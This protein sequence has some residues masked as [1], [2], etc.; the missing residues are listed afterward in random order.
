MPLPLIA[1]LATGL[2]GLGTSLYGVNK[3]S[4]AVD[5]AAKLNDA[6]QAEQNAAAWANYLMTRGLS[7][8]GATTGQIP[9]GAAAINARLPLWA[10][11]NFARP[12][13]KRVWRKKGAV[14]PVNTLSRTSA[15][16]NSYVSAIASPSM[17]Y[18]D[19]GGG[20]FIPQ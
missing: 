13:A 18:G 12:E 4:K 11:A 15:P 10:T 19:G 20:D 3:Q 7:P 14:A 16:G 1:T 6:R 17:Y 9:Q 2:L 5:E 8:A